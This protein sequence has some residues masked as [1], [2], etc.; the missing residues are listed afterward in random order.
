MRTGRLE[1]M[2]G[3]GERN[4][5]LRECGGR[6]RAMRRQWWGDKERAERK[7][8]EWRSEVVKK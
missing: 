1:G 7:W 6:G 2:K 5:G 4:G 8:R 3:E